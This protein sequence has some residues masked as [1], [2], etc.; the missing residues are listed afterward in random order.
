MVDALAPA[1]SLNRRRPRVGISVRQVA[2]E[3]RLV[4]LRLDTAENRQRRPGHVVVLG[5]GLLEDCRQ[6]VGNLGRGPNRQDLHRRVVQRPLLGA[7]GFQQRGGNNGRLVGRQGFLAGAADGLTVAGHVLQQAVDG[8]GQPKRAD[9]VRRRGPDRRVGM[10]EL[11]QRTSA[12]LGGRHVREGQRRAAGDQWVLVGQARPDHVPPVLAPQD[13][14]RHHGLAANDRAGVGEALLDGRNALGRTDHPQRLHRR[15]A[16]LGQLAAGQRQHLSQGLLAS[17]RR[18]GHQRLAPD[19]RALFAGQKLLDRPG[20]LFHP[21]ANQQPQ[22]FGLQDPTVRV[23]VP[24]RP[25]DLQ[26]RWPG[27]GGTGPAG[28]ARR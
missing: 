21:P 27:R 18:Q 5:T 19:P 3:D 17:K 8:L 28:G 12:G 23:Q 9:H 4:P 13:R 11:G 22:G 10:V 16:K 7:Q 6:F 20:R 2:D 25:L 15:G 26:G 14:C 24:H 1:Q